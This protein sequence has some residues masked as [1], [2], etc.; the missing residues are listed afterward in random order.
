MTSSQGKVAIVGAGI[1][2]AAIARALAREG[3]QVIV[4][5]PR[6]VGSGATAAGMGHLVVMD[7]SEAQ[8]A[9]SRYS[10]LLWDQL[11]PSLP[12]EVEF[13]RF[14]T[15]WVAADGGEM[16]EV[17]RKHN[18]FLEREVKTEILNGKE[19][20]AHEPNLRS[21]LAGGL[22]VPGDSVL[23]PVCAARW[24]L[25]EAIQYGAELQVGKPVVSLTGQCAKLADNSLIHADI[26]VNAAGCLATR[27]TAGLEV[28][29]RKGHLVITDRYPGFVQHQLLELGY[30]KS[31][32]GSDRE[33]VAFNVQ[34][35][36]TGQLL[37]GS[38]RQFG[39]EEPDVDPAILRKMIL[40]A[41]AYMP[42]LK[43]VSALRVWTGLRAATP[44]SLPLIGPHPDYP[45]LYLATG[46]EGLGITTSLA[47]AEIIA[48]HLMGRPSA[49]PSD[50][51]LPARFGAL[52]THA[53][54][55]CRDNQRS[56][57]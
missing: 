2:G 40:R 20:S 31:A 37:I 23:Y 14:G 48:D 38:S 11:A 35:R 33:S 30:L 42:G 19:L 45:H 32:H 39:S 24:L 46:H 13:S 56:P 12:P 41:L 53:Q 8:F 28:R 4:I 47:T 29:P 55:D 44:D 52:M 26:I 50:P 15:I 9:L 1:V 22:R 21:G 54:F 6:P 36:P 25:E 18:F 27:L 34:P 49:I 10:Q 7:D 16:G 57:D 3:F 17:H 51:Y 5:D 43:S